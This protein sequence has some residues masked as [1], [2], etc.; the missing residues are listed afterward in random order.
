VTGRLASGQPGMDRVLGGGLPANAINMIIGAPGSGKT[1]L[2]QQ[3]VFHNATPGHP[4]LYL[5]TVSE[6]FDK[7]LR[8]GQSLHFFDASRVGRDVLY[9]DLGE[10]LNDGGLDQ[11]LERISDLL[12][13]HRPGMV[14][15]DSFKAL[16]AFARNEQAF[17][18]FLHDLAGRLSVLPLSSFWVGEY[19]RDA[20]TDLAE[21]AVADAIVSLST[22]RT[23]SREM[24]VV[25]VLKLR[26][27]SFQGGTHAYR[28]TANGLRVFPR[29]ADP[30]E[31]GVYQLGDQRVSTG[32]PALDGSL[33][34]GYWPG[35]STLVAGP[36]GAGKTIM[37]LHFVFQGAHQGSPGLF[38]TLQENSSQ[39]GRLAAGFGW[40]LRDDDV[41]V[42]ARTPVD[43]Y[44][45]EWVY[46]LL[47]EA[48]R[49][50]AR[51]IVVDSLGDLTLAAS[52]ELRFREYMY[53]L[54]Q[55]CSRAGVSLLLTLEIPQLFTVGRLSDLGISHLSDNVLLL[56]Y[57]REEAQVKRAMTVL[58]TRASHHHAQIREFHID[59]DGIR[60][61]APITAADRFG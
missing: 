30:L 3:Y 29:L 21:F 26:G 37:G 5:S 48:E 28:I 8:Y 1:I 50:G 7:I 39:L 24:R 38:A 11:V 55:R 40:D 22:T 2:A 61:G 9:E 16:G 25:Q 57:V 42:M 44:I 23:D 56:Q 17:R 36:S 58:K 49:T 13:A 6:P 4:A 18:R 32:I 54:M 12:R 10:V 19:D 60:L 35:S 15:I 52:D 27:S 53:S 41:H 20:A 33:A 47:D 34:E 51:R 46:E 59:P 31:V 45:D 43:M 14:V